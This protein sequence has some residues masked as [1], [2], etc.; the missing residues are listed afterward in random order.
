MERRTGGLLVPGNFLEKDSCPA[1]FDDSQCGDKNNLVFQANINFTCVVCGLIL[2]TETDIES[3]TDS[4][5]QPGEQTGE[6]N[7][8]DGNQ[9]TGDT[10]PVDA[11]D[12]QDTPEEKMV[13]NTQVQ[14]REIIEELNEGEGETDVYT[15]FFIE[16]F[17][18]I[19]SFYMLFTKHG[20]FHVFEQIPNKK[21]KILEVAAAYM[22]IE[23][24]DTRFKLLATVT[25]YPS[26][27]NLINKALSF[28]KTY[29][30]EEYQEGA[31]LIEIYAPALRLP[32]SFVEPMKETWLTINHP[33]GVTQHKVVAFMVA[34]AGFFQQRVTQ[35]VASEMTGVSR[36]SL[37]PK[38]KQY[39]EIL[40]EY[41]PQ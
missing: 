25:G 13:R 22:M 37:S 2:H 29:K 27:S 40:K 14:F 35:Q 24:G 9:D 18:E 17:D 5:F 36:T 3:D 4:D 30:G 8:D 7:E 11:L 19:V 1:G 26:E 41:L 23:R 38:I 33:R 12:V 20:P 15:G 31:Y 39:K 10:A 34:Y 6:N 28:I 16:K 32:E 21:R